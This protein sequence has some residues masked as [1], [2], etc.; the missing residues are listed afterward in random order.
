MPNEKKSRFM[1]SS[2]AVVTGK[3]VVKTLFS[4]L[5]QKKSKTI[6]TLTTENKINSNKH[7]PTLLKVHGWSFVDS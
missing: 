6:H 7:L 1:L 5:Q 3:L 4:N 2:S